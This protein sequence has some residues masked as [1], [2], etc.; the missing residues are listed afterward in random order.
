MA[1]FTPGI[2]PYVFTNNNSMNG[3]DDYGLGFWRDAWETI[4]SVILPIVGFTKHGGIITSEA[5]NRYYTWDHKSK[6][7]S[8]RRSSSNNTHVQPPSVPSSTSISYASVETEKINYSQVEVP[9]LI[10]NIFI[11][12]IS[13]KEGEKLTYN[14]E[15]R[16]ETNSDRFYNIEA[17][18]DALSELVNSLKSDP[19]INVFI[20]GNTG[21]PNDPDE[22]YGSSD[23]ALNSPVF[24]NGKMK[25]TRD[26]MNA[27]AKAVFNYLIR[28]GID[29][30]RLKYGPGIRYNNIS[31]RKTTFKL[32]K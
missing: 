13:M 11:P 10:T 22:I 31:G 12:P 5:R 9:P 15:I 32:F 25:T 14:K 27:R 17:T 16:F 29:S 23:D 24:V 28:H 3:I 7:H 18:D 8:N 1:I 20:Q 2:S 4:K 30:K 19:A 6:S 21:E 26:L